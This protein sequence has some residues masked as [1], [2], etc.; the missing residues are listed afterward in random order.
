M[1]NH[2]RGTILRLRHIIHQRLECRHIELEELTVDLWIALRAESRGDDYPECLVMDRGRR[3]TDAG[4]PW[5]SIRRYW[6]IRNDFRRF[7]ALAGDVK[8]EKP[9]QDVDSLLRTHDGRA[10]SQIIERRRKRSGVDARCV[11]LA[12]TNI[13]PGGRRLLNDAPNSIRCSLVS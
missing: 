13:V 2:R 1:Q 3:K 5:R 8:R 12:A 11:P 4:G 6:L 7:A 10:G 9:L